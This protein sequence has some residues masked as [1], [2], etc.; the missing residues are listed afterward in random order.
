MPPAASASVIVAITV[1]PA[2]VTSAISIGAEDRN[3]HRRLARLEQRHAAAAARDQHARPS[4]CASAAR[5][6][7]ARA[8]RWLSSIVDAEHLLDFRFVRRARGQAAI[9]RQRVARIDQDRHAALLRARSGAASSATKRGVHQAGAVVGDQH[10]V[11]V[12]DRARRGALERRRAARR[13]TGSRG[14]AI[15]AHDLLL[16]RVDAA[17]EDARLDRRAIAA[18]PASGPRARPRAAAP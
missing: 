13:S 7:R 15:D 14:V 6:R 9:A 16:R 11:G 10:R 8:P 1:S 3:V 12:R 2:P 5:G 18:G 17:G 4:A